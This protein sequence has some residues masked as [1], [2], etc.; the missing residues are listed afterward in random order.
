MALDSRQ[1]SVL[2]IVALL[3]T[4]AAV[5][6]ARGLEQDESETAQVVTPAS[7][8]IPPRAVTDAPATPV[9]QS[10]GGLDLSRLQRAPSA[11]PGADLFGQPQIAVAAAPRSARGSASGGEMPEAPPPP[12]PAPPPLPFTYLGQLVE[13][14]RTMVFLSTGDR[15]HVVAPGEV[16]DNLYRI[17]EIGASAVVI[18]YLPMNTQQTLPTGAMP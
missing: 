13:A 1:R 17:D 9:V 8:S 5:Y 7:R 14:G 6:W 18:T 4:L 10:A 2:L 11:Q 12:P 15:N 3:A 16:I